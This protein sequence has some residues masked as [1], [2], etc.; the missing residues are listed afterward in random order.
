MGQT[1]N[2][3]NL[4]WNAHRYNC[5]RFHRNF[6]SIDNGDE[7]ALFKHLFVNHRGDIENIGMDSAYR[8]MFLKQPELNSLTTKKVYGLKN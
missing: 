1:K 2:N 7:S 4:R 8:I 6:S 3:F 5:K